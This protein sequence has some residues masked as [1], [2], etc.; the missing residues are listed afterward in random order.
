MMSHAGGGG[1]FRTGAAC[2]CARET[3]DAAA[4]TP[5]GR[6]RRYTWFQWHDGG[7]K[8]YNGMFTSGSDASYLD[9][10][11]YYQ[12]P[13]LSIKACCYHLMLNGKQGRVGPLGGCVLAPRLAVKACIA[14]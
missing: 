7:G 5:C 13:L 2:G 4:G 6:R 3:L 12:L 8:R 1:P 14:S 11:V 9:L 10:A